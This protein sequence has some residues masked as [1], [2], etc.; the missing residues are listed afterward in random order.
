MN[1]YPT[2]KSTNIEWIGDIPEHWEVKKLNYC[3]RNIG[4]GTT[5]TST[6]SEYYDNEGHNWLQT[7]DLTDNEILETSKKITDL[8]LKDFS[9]LKFYPKDSIVIAMYGATIG[10]SGILKIETTT[11]QACCVMSEPKD[12]DSKYVF[13]WFNSIKNHVISLSYGG[14]Q[15]NINQ[16]QIRSLK[17]QLPSIEEQTTI[18]TYLDHKTAQIDNIIANK[19]KL[20]ALYEEEKQTIINQAVTRGIKKD[21]ALKP[22]GVEWLGDIPEHW[23]VKRLKYIV[24]LITE[25]ANGI[26][27]KIGL[28]NIESK[29]GKYIETNSD[30]EGEGISYLVGDILYGKLRPYLAKVWLSE[31]DGAAVGDFFVLRMRE[32]CL[33]EY[34]KFRLLSTSFTEMSNG[35][36]FGAKMPRVSW[37]FMSDLYFA[38]PEYSEQKTIFSH[39]EMECTRLGTLIDKFKAQIELF[40]EYRNTLISDVVTGKVKVI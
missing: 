2:Y 37:E 13:Y 35:S 16:E 28:E 23:E 10:K 6:K 30:F 25:K 8:A 27:T 29:T 12:L 18:A 17:I 26:I 5:P 7:G 22:S 11:N 39:I 24:K 21:V 14:G 32:G 36:T 34:I 31:F 19:Q 15:P 38:L 1:K 3:F 4:S 20:I 33:N 40:Q 9:T